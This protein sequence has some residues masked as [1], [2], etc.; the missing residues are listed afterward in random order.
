MAPTA[1]CRLLTLV[2]CFFYFVAKMNLSIVVHFLE[3]SLLLWY[4]SHSFLS[5]SLRLPAQKWHSRSPTLSK[6]S[7]SSRTFVYPSSFLVS[8]SAKGLGFS[9]P[10]FNPRSPFSLVWEA[11]SFEN[12]RRTDSLS[13]PIPFSCP[14]VSAP[15]WVNFL[16]F[17]SLSLSFV[18]FFRSIALSE[19]IMAPK[20]RNRRD[21]TLVVSVSPEDIQGGKER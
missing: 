8:S 19:R 17:F 5:S 1:F 9:F 20:R 7:L 2:W 15:S 11:R 14:T 12:Y 21:P 13:L 3:L 18:L 6:N 4:S 16:P 10:L